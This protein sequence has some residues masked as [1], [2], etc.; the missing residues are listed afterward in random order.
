MRQAV[1]LLS[2]PVVTHFIVQNFIEQFMSVIT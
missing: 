1:L 2:L